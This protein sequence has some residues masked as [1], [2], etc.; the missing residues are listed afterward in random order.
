MPASLPVQR[1]GIRLFA[2]AVDEPRVRRIFD[3]LALGLALALLA[4]LAWWGQPTRSFERSLVTAA[5]SS[6]GWLRGIWVVAYDLMLCLPV[7]V[8]A[9]AVVRRRWPIVVQCLVAGVAAIA[10]VL[11][12]ARLTGDA[13]PSIDEAVGLGDALTWPAGAL[14]VCAATLLCVS[15]DVTKP[16]RRLSEWTIGAGAL[17]AV[18]AARATVSGALAALLVAVAAAAIA[19]LA[20]GTT[21]GHLSR[22]AILELLDLLGV[23]VAEVIGQ[24]RLFDGL[25]L[26]EARDSSG[27]ALLVKVRGRDAAE[28]RRIERLWRG[29]VYRD[30]GAAFAQVRSPGLE[31][32]AFATLLAAAHGIPVWEVVTAGRPE[33]ADEALVLRVDGERASALA[34]DR[35]DDIAADSAWSAVQ[36]LHAA[37]IAHLG[38]GPA[39]IALRADGT[40]ALTDM[41]DAT[42]AASAS[43]LHTDDSQLLVLLAVLLGP[44]RAVQ[45]ARRALDDERLGGMLSYLQSA[46]LPRDLRSAARNAKLDF[47]ALRAA[48]AEAAGIEPPELARL[49]RVTGGGLVRTG[50]LILAAAAIVPLLASIDFDQFRASLSSAS[51]GYVVAGFLVAQT[52]RLAQTVSTLGSVPA[53]LPFGPVYVMQLATS[54]L[55]IALPSATARMA[56]SVRF[57][58]KQGVAP[59]TAVTSGLIDSLIGNVIQALL[60]GA[61]LLFT[62]LSLNIETDVS[63]PDASSTSLLAVLLLLLALVIG[64]AV[65]IP[66]VRNEIVKRAREWWPGLRAGL[67]P[68]RSGHKSAQLIGGNIAAE[69][70]FASA[71]ALCV[72]AFGGDIGLVE[73]LLVT[74][75]ASLLVTF[76]PIPGGIGVAEGVLIVGLTGLGVDE[77]TAFAATIAYRMSTFYLPPFW[78]YLAMSWLGRNR[79]L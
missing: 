3:V 35:F 6:P 30:G 51:W 47:D 22:T 48:T 70:L 52:P 67:D 57:F 8:I 46:A 10:L 68:L 56:L 72:R 4:V 21:A 61:I 33:G 18:L 60:L 9:A 62:S 32:E 45:S 19:R 14:T 66:R 50:L 25:V 37:R 7:V 13:W 16:M 44:E 34:G 5:V 42:V 24:R 38:L 53:R 36:G 69:I 74:M 64:A 79:Y 78:G 65:A 54:F 31:R 76:I 58:Q 43:A 40:V 39:A 41:T 2:S 63:F 1:H 23:R 17:T 28:S 55:N 27:A 73:A 75:S 29:L 59:A 11:V 71:L 77:E 49:Q 26:V 15:A 12:V 20:V